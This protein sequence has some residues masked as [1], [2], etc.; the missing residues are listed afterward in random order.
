MGSENDWEVITSGRSKSVDVR[1]IE[2]E[3]TG[4]WKSAA[5]PSQREGG[6]AVTRTCILNLVV[7]AEGE[8]MEGRVKE[9]IA[10][11]TERHPCRAIVMVAGPNATS[12]SLDAWISVHCH[13]SSS[14]DRQVCCEQVTISAGGEAVR[15]LPGAVVPLLIPDLPVFLWWPGTPHFESDLLS[16]ILDDSDHFIVDSLSF[17]SPADS[18][19]RI[20]TLLSKGSRRWSLKDL[21]WLRLSPWRELIA[22]FF[23][24]PD[25]RL[26]LSRLKEV[27][28]EYAMEAGGEESNP[29]QALLLAGWL[30]SR[31]GWELDSA[32]SRDGRYS[33]RMAG[34]SGFTS[35][36]IS[37][38]GCRTCGTGEL[39]SCELRADPGTVF[40]VSRGDTL[41]IATA[42]VRIAGERFLDRTARVES[43]D[44]RQLLCGALEILSRD[45]V[46][47][48]ALKMAGIMLGGAMGERRWWLI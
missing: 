4:L 12:P 42:S 32:E 13:L 8:G 7:Y 19:S 47:E 2:A 10:D 11:V 39:L 3:L 16:R 40:S 36:E 17:R 14:G 9:V 34:G 37:G 23:D 5:E 30:A 45:G 21:N 35:I 18:L 25:L 29:S 31:L 1:S 44:E 24:I 20:A 41:E 38:G 6:S 28:I 22:Q 48:E 43:L 33:L 46:F 27:A 15:S 26:Y